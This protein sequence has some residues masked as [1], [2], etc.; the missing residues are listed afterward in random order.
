MLGSATIL[1]FDGN[2]YN[3]FDLSLA[4][5]ERDGRVSGPVS[6]IADV[7]TIL[8]SQAIAAA[9]VDCDI[10]GSEAADVVMLLAA[11][12]IPMIVQTAWPSSLALQIFEGKA[13]VLVK[14]VDPMLLL[15]ILLFAI[16]CA[17]QSTARSGKSTNLEIV[18]R[19]WLPQR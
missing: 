17:N 2:A 9:I 16:D 5:E 19:C 8:E 7:R 18:L 12:H 14:P 15:D 10:D 1:I 13:M 4:I 3:S 11:N 6:T